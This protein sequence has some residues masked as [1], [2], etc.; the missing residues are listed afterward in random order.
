[1]PPGYLSKD[2]V[3]PIPRPLQPLAPGLCLPTHSLS[4]VLLSK[5]HSLQGGVRSGGW[6]RSGLGNRNDF[7]VAMV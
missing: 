1:M 2:G 5:T 4:L 3:G 6:R 7:H